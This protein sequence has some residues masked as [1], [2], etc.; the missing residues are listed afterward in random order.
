[1]VDAK[2]ARGPIPGKKPGPAPKPKH[3]K[4]DKRVGLSLTEEEAEK[5][6]AKT[7]GGLIKEATV[8]HKFLRDH[9]FFD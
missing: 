9:G 8:I 1:M 5:L 6:A 7:Q 4:Q 3:T 2:P